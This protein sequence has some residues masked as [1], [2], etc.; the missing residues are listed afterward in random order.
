MRKLLEELEGRKELTEGYTHY[1]S[2]KGFSDKGWLAFT[3]DVGAIV[4][5]AKKDIKPS[6][7]SDG[8]YIMFNGEGQDGYEDLLITLAPQEGFNFVKT[9]GMRGI[10]PYDPF[11]VEILKAAKKRNRSVKLKSDGGKEVFEALGDGKQVEDDHVVAERLRGELQKAG[12]KVLK[13]GRRD[14]IYLKD[15]DR[16]VIRIRDKG[17][18]YIEMHD[19]LGLPRGTD[20]AEVAKTLKKEFSF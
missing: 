5:K 11:V 10:K 12:I 6:L 17:K 18:I 8:T 2:H 20:G 4:K 7:D 9:G 14:E 16:V 15:S 13:G 3:K 19:K 1:F